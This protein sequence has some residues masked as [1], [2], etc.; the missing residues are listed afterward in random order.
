MI[1]IPRNGISLIIPAFADGTRSYARPLLVIETNSELNTI[2]LLNVSSIEGKKPS[3]LL[4]PSNKELQYY[5]PPFNRASFVKLDELYIIDYFDDL[6][7]L[8][9]QSGLLDNNEF[10]RI[11]N[12]F[13]EY[14]KRL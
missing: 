2:S 9:F 4:I 5:N 13:N 14:K 11:T 1:I 6:N 7:K 12:L 3:K 10:I 8:I